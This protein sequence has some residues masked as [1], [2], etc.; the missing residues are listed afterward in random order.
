MLVPRSSKTFS[1]RLDKASAT[2]GIWF[3]IIPRW[4]PFRPAQVPETCA[5]CAMSC[6]PISS[7]RAKSPITAGKQLIARAACQPFAP[8]VHRAA[9]EQDHGWSLEA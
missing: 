6:G 5:L 3:G 4:T 8:C 2:S 1:H 7:R 9:A